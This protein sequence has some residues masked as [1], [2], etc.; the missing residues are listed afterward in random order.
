VCRTL[1]GPPL[2]EL[3]G[4]QIHPAAFAVQQDPAAPGEPGPEHQHR[5][6]EHRCAE[7]RPGPRQGRERGGRCQRGES[8]EEGRLDGARRPQAP[9]VVERAGAPPVDD[10]VGVVLDQPAQRARP[11]APVA[12]QVDEV[13]VQG[14]PQPAGVAPVGSASLSGLAIVYF[15][16][17]ETDRWARPGV[18]RRPGQNILDRHLPGT[19]QGIRQARPVTSARGID[20]GQQRSR[21]AGFTRP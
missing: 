10:G 3:G 5:Q 4:V 11:D 21:P 6:G 12:V 9:E 13:A 16:H 2:G 20:L 14:G 18:S 19:R 8:A 17:G 1:G 15:R 7:D